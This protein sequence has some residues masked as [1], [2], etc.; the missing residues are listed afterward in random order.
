MNAR[1][2]IPCCAHCGQPIAGPFPD[3]ESI[4]L[5]R[6]HRQVLK[7]LIDAHG[8]YV[9]AARVAELVYADDPDG[10]PLG[11]VD[12]VSAFA[13]HLRRK[14]RPLGWNIESKRFAGYRIVKT[15]EAA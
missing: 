4:D 15:P 6:R 10:G 12:I 2:S 14:M 13:H 1:V 5:Q 9:P 8:R 11:A 7:I 3:P